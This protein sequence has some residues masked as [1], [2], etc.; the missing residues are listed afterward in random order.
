MNYRHRF[1]AGNV[2]DVFKHLVLVR[3]LES[4]RAK[5]TPFCAIDTHAGSGLY[6]LKPP[7][8]FMHGIGRLWP[9]RAEW[10]ALAGYFERIQ[11]YNTGA[12]RA[13]P[14]SPLIIADLLRPQDRAV[15]VERHPEECA[16]LRDNLRCAGTHEGRERRT[17]R[18]GRGRARIA[19]HEAD[20]LAMLGALLPPPENRGLV[21]IDP[22]Y[23]AAGE[24]AAVAAALPPA[25]RRWRNGV[26]MIWYPI[27]ARRPVEQ[28][29]AAVAALGH[30]AVAI[31]LLTLP[32]DV[33]QR[34]NGSGVVVINPPWR[35]GEVLTSFLSGLA[36]FL[37]GP[38]GAPRVRIVSL[39]DS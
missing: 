1:H 13:Y 28:L 11:A 32:E 31:E 29:H 9:V 27:K 33:P 7:G 24:F 21:L 34:L 10:P 17:R 20:G 12:L 23:E 14:G 18:S 8:E 39:H 25:L 36:E 15:F 19:V 16:G 5:D 37:A 2:A 35:L 6:R 22:P 3:V 30:E 26:Y 4:L 38:G